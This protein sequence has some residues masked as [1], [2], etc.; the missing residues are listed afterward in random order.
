MSETKTTISR[1]YGNY[2]FPDYQGNFAL[3]VF[4][5]IIWLSSILCPNY[6]QKKMSKMIF[7]PRSKNK[8]IN[9]VFL[10]SAVAR[11]EVV[12][13]SGKKNTYYIWG[14]SKPEILLVHGW[15]SSSSTFRV[16]INCLEKK[17]YSVVSFDACA[18]GN[19][20][21]SEA[22]MNDFIDGIIS[23]SKKFTSIRCAIGYS[24]GGLALLNAINHGLDLEKV[25]IISAP[26]SFYG[27]FEK[28]AAQLKLS[29][30]IQDHLS[31]VL[32][33]RYKINDKN[34]DKYSSYDFASNMTV[35]LVAIHDKNDTYI[36]SIESEILAKLWPGSKLLETEKL[37][38][39]G[40]LKNHLAMNS[41]I[42]ELSI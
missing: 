9:D 18:H 39:R 28:V 3:K 25:G 24:F 30:S 26:S 12:L 36:L 5:R 21:G 10:K 15:E 41:L 16:L 38:H 4:R 31:R 1:S 34:W 13:R 20:E 17:G 19:S 33:E 14:G 7:E 23:L 32:I 37:G 35:P 6:T 40:I 27:I 2:N 11:D 29:R 42:D 8:K 22:D